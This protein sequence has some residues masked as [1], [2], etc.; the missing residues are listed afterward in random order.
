MM[1]VGA[2]AVCRRLEAAA[3]GS[4]KKGGWYATRP[5]LYEGL[6]LA[7]FRRCLVADTHVAGCEL[8]A[9]LGQC[10]FAIFEW[11]EARLSDGIVPASESEVVG[12]SGCTAEVHCHTGFQLHQV[13]QT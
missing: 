10:R 12:R 1:D 11:R 8:G 2:G 9:G 6:L 4:K 7:V 5:S 13:S 3:S